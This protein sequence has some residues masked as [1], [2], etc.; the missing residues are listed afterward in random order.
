MFADR[1]DAGVQLGVAL[2]E[3][4]PWPQGLILALPRGGAV[5]AAE[6]AMILDLPWDLL[7]VRKLGVP[8]DEELAF[9]AVASG[10]GYVHNP[11]V[12]RQAGLSEAEAASIRQRE[13]KILKEQ[14]IRLRGKRP[15]PEIKGRTIILV[16]DGMATGASMQVAV[17]MLRQWQAGHLVVAVPVASAESVRL[18]G[19]QV[20][21]VVCLSTPGYFSSIGQWYDDFAQVND[22]EVRR[23]LAMQTL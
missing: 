3:A 7:M 8:S 21:K 19:S 9:G 13:E 11:L 15:Y 6:A 2:K 12:M 18:L 20:E 16:D 22:Q 14:A 5:V 23:L 17:H 4:G 1:Q 10:G